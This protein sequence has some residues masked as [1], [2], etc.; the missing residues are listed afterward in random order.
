VPFPQMEAMLS[1]GKIDAISV[2]EPFATAA[3]EKGNTRL[4]AHPWGD[5]LPKF[6]IA[7]WFASEKWI[8]K[9]KETAQAFVRAINRCIDAIQAD[10]EASRAAMIKWAGLNPDLAAK[11]GL[12]GFEKTISEKDLQAT[13]DLTQKYKLI[14]KGIKARDVISDLAPKG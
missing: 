13:I 3:I 10:P 11:I 6:L 14:A 7:S 2:H 5:V 1:A 8:A 9:N 4:L 12:P